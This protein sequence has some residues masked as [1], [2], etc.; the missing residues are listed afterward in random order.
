[1]AASFS[2]NSSAIDRSTST[3]LADM[4]ICPWW[5]NAPNAVAFTAYSR[6]ASA[7]TMTGL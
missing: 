6:S 7:R 2:V 4:Q 5:R 1:L 3:F